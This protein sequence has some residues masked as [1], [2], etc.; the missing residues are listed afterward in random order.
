[1]RK[2]QT[3]SDKAYEMVSVCLGHLSRFVL[4]RDLERQRATIE[5]LHEF[6]VEVTIDYERA[7]VHVIERHIANDA[8]VA[9]RR[10]RKEARAA[11]KVK[12][13]A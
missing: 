11:A 6:G 5:V 7:K 10:K 4:Q 8:K 13:E 12:D 3:I 9:E 1:M 2:R